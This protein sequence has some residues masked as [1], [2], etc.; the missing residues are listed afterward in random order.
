MH[1]CHPWILA[2]FIPLGKLDLIVSCSAPVSPKLCKIFWDI[3]SICLLFLA[4]R[5]F[6]PLFNLLKPSLPP[7]LLTLL[8]NPHPDS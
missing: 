4:T 6:R 1:V 7:L 3:S 5:S 8:E 2:C